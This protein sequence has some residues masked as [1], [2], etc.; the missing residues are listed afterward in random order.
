[1][2]KLITT[3]TILL[4]ALVA[5]A[6]INKIKTSKLDQDGTEISSNYTFYVSESYICFGL[7]TEKKEDYTVILIFDKKEVDL[8]LGKFYMYS[9]KSGYN[10]L[11]KADYKEVM[12]LGK[13]DFMF[14]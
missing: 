4:F 11:I 6:Q 13:N 1:M 12:I 8:P 14:Y 7:D 9:T 5:N 2:R 10:V 3:I